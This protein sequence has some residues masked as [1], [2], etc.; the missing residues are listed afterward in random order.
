LVDAKFAELLET[1]D[2]R[3]DDTFEAARDVVLT[4][5]GKQIMDNI[6]VLLSALEKE[7]SDLL[8]VRSAA[9]ESG[10]SNAKQILIFGSLAAIALLM[11][12]AFYLARSLSNGANKV[13]VAL[14][15]IALGDLRIE[16]VNN[17]SGELGDMARS[18]GQ[19]RVYLRETAAAAEAFSRGDLSVEIKA[20][21]E[22]DALGNAFVEMIGNLRKV[23]GQVA[24]AANALTGSSGELSSAAEQAGS[25]TQDIASNSQRLASG[26][27]EQAKSVEATR[28]GVQQLQSAIVQVAQG[29]QAQAALVEQASTIVSQVSGATPDVARNAVDAATAGRESVQKTMEG[30]E[31]IRGAVSSA[32]ERI[33]ELSEYSAEIG[34]IVSVIDDI[35]AQTNLLALNAAIEAARAG[36]QGRGFAVV[37]DEVRKLAERVT[38]ATKEIASLIDTVQKGVTDSVKAT[39]EGTSEVEAG[40]QLAGE[41]SDALNQILESV[42]TVKGQVERISAAAEEVSASSDEMVKIIESISSS[43]EQNSAA[44]EQMSASSTEVGQSIESVSSVTDQNRAVSEQT[45]ASAE[46]LSAQVEEVVAASQSLAGMAD[47]LQNVVCTFKLKEGQEGRSNGRGTGRGSYAESEVRVGERIGVN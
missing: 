21:S 12:V 10:A 39:E 19:M 47:D 25:A 17:S 41:A 38:G 28:S 32:S 45:S 22:D 6:R 16:V 43:A 11:G 9:A 27:E 33:E 46:E 26:A 40:T 23:I 13:G 20:K 1:I 14:K 36:E 31:R 7:E 24:D 4:D 2:L 37:A 5:A 15:Q 30:M 42:D 18:Y 44:A 29:S 35:A 8:V 34:K 3:R